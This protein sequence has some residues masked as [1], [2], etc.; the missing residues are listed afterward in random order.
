M[1]SGRAQIILS[2]SIE[3]DIAKAKQVNEKAEAFIVQNVE[4]FLLDNIIDG[5]AFEGI[6]TV[7]RRYTCNLLL[8][9]IIS[10]T[11]L[12]LDAP[13]IKSRSRTSK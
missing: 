13:L 5:G 10:L 7:G 1:A 12:I 6:L 9:R 8:L 11:Y 3:G 4:P 2:A